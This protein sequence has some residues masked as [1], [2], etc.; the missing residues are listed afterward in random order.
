M[1]RHATREIELSIRDYSKGIVSGISERGIKKVNFLSGA[2][3]LYGR[4]YRGLRMRPGSRDLSSAILSDQPHSL[5]GFYATG[6]N[7][8]FVGAANKILE[9]TDDSYDL[10]TLP[11]TPASSDIWTHTNLDAALIATQ[12]GGSLTPLMYDGAWK[13]LKLPKP[14]LAVTFGADTNTGGLVDVG[15]HYYRVRWRYLRGSSLVGPVSAAHVIVAPNQTVH[16]TANLVPPTPRSDYI[17]WTLERTKVNSDGSNGPWWFL[18]D[19]TAATYDDLKPDSQLGYQADEGLH[20]EPL[21]FDGVT[22]FAGRL[23]G[24]NASI[25]YASQAA[26]GDL[27]ATGIANFDAD[28]TYPITKDDGDVI[29]VCLVAIDELVILKRRSLHVISGVDPDSFV[30]TSVVL[31][32]PSRGSEAGCGGPRAACVIGGTVYFWGESGGLFTY[33]RG[34][35]KPAGWIEMGRYL[36]ELNT[37][38]LDQLLL[39]NHQGNYML[40]WYPRGASIV[41]RD[42]V[43]YDARLKQWWHW[44]GWAARDAIELKSG[45]FGNAS[46][47]IAD[48][49]NRATFGA[50]ANLTPISGP[51]IQAASVVAGAVLLG[52]SSLTMSKTALITAQ[53]VALVIGGTAIGRCNTTS[54]S[55]VVTISEYHCWAP[56]DSFQDEKSASGFTGSIPGDTST[57]PAE[58]VFAFAGRAPA[59]QAQVY[60]HGLSVL[61]ASLWPAGSTLV[62]VNGALAAIESVTIAD[63]LGGFIVVWNDARSGTGDIYAQ[64]Y[65]ASG[66][67]L[68]AAGGVAVNASAL[69]Q[70]LPQAIPDGSGGAIICWQDNRSGTSK[71]FAQRISAAGFLQWTP[72]GVAVATTA[73][74]QTTPKM[75]SDLTGGAII[76]WQDAAF[77]GP[78]VQRIVGLDGSPLWTAAGVSMGGGATGIN[79]LICS[80]GATGC[81]VVWQNRFIRGIIGPGTFA[82]PL[83]DLGINPVYAH[84][85][86]DG[87]GG[88]YL[89]YYDGQAR[90]RRVTSGGAFAWAATNLSGGSTNGT[91][92]QV[93]TDGSFGAIVVWHDLFSGQH[94]I[95]AQRV[96][97]A[98]AAQWNAGAAVTVATN[99]PSS[100]T[101]T[102]PA[103]VSDGIGGAFIGWYVDTG[104]SVFDAVAQRIDGDGNSLWGASAVVMKS[105]AVNN[106]STNF[107]MAAAVSFT[108]VG[109]SS[110]ATPTTGGAPVLV[111][112]ETPWLDG[113]LPDDWKALD[114]ISMTAE[115]DLTAISIVVTTDPPGADTA[116]TLRTVGQGADW[117]ADSGSN[118][119]DLEWDVGDWASDAPTT[120]AAGVR[121]GTIARRFKFTATAQPSGDHRPTGLEAIAVLLPDKEYNR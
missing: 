80:D 66:V 76:C 58:V 55:A 90:V 25:L 101:S 32:D 85:C 57:V 59:Q 7:K 28:L 94:C 113:G 71:I 95:R 96:N 92:P 121:P 13:E 22:N 61:G 112:Q 73:G 68:W 89:A 20:G 12:R 69:A 107:Y 46:M 23:W 1:S 103:A 78:G 38:A 72:S 19:G 60:A 86:S 79:P 49:T 83:I 82:W 16:I 93:M 17:G 43:M 77:T 115:G 44:K 99:G 97:S 29:Q 41:S 15:T 117:A 30:L 120:V 100:G 37:A 118:P 27:E 36:D 26:D 111:A 40:A 102:G 114:R 105:A 53:N 56:F 62:S 67:A 5:L 9:I 75:C 74:A 33:S 8:L 119:N 47:A 6:G 88:A 11:A 110:V 18:A 116:L 54:G 21:H 109:S 52:A 106:L 81:I 108:T 14:A 45:L 104:A 35:V 98:G 70:S 64:R 91:S 50:I 34:S 87:A 24:W 51:G 84:L 39:I 48:P 3:N 65:N 10:Q 31:A 4:P 2:D 63:G 42:Q